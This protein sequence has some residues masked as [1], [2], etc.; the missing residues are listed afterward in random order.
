MISICRI[1]RNRR[2]FAF[3]RAARDERACREQVRAHRG[4]GGLPRRRRRLGRRILN[5]GRPGV[6]GRRLRV[7]ASNF[8][9]RPSRRYQPSASAS[10]YQSLRG[11]RSSSRAPSH[12][13]SS[14]PRRLLRALRPA[15]RERRGP[16]GVIGGRGG[17]LFAS[18][19]PT[20]RH[21]SIQMTSSIFEHRRGRFS[22]APPPDDE[23][24][25][26]RGEPRRLPE[27]QR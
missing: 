4:R 25:S 1:N 21:P 16:A 27:R 26:G 23:R 8:S 22:S 14:S 12:T 6:V 20:H 11:P 10:A 19:P 5:A 18:F 15:L 9:G 17:R 24:R 7:R 3:G 13:G 2:P